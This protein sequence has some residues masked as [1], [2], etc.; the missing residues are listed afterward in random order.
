MAIGL[1]S[2]LVYQLKERSKF[3]SCEARQGFF[4]FLADAGENKRLNVV[5]TIIF[6]DNSMK[7]AK[8]IDLQAFLTP[9][10]FTANAGLCRR[11]LYEL[12]NHT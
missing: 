1:Q 4:F 7:L 6:T 11:K 5:K 10:G 12:N 9:F 8:I 3:N 2:K